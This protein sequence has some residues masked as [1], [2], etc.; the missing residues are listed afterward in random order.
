MRK[1]IPVSGRHENED[2]KQAERVKGNGQ[3]PKDEPLPKD[4]PGGKHRKE[5]GGKNE[6]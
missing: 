3:R 4:D 6:K 5:D 1:E 2:D